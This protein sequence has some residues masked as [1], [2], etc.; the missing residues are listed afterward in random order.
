MS[1][2]LFALTSTKWRD[3]DPGHTVVTVDTDRDADISLVDASVHCDLDTELV[4][5]TILDAGT[6]TTLDLL[7]VALEEKLETDSLGR[8]VVTRRDVKVL[9]GVTG[10]CSAVQVFEGDVQLVTCKVSNNSKE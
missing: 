7:A 5:L 4:D 10:G 3:I 2:K 1:L 6:D 9:D 8:V